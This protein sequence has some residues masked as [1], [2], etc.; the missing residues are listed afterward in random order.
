M[1]TPPPASGCRVTQTP[2]PITTRQIVASCAFFVFA[3]ILGAFCCAGN[4]NHDQQ[5]QIIN[6][7]ASVV[8]TDTPSPIPAA[9]VIV[10]SPVDTS[11]WPSAPVGGAGT[12]K[13][14]AFCSHAGQ[15]GVT[16]AGTP[17]ACQRAADGK[18]RWS[19]I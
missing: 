17:M 2:T 5:K 18:L 11:P 10:A 16:S 4:R 9:S 19:R 1:V 7:L 13:A 12:V 6:P 8:I 14:G 3:C 15:T